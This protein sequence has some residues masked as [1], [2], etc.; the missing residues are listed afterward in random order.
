V[1]VAALWLWTLSRR[2]WVMMMLLVGT[3]L[4]FHLVL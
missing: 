4:I 2:G 3:G 1:L